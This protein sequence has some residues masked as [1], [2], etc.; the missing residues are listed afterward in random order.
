LR[1]REVA[2]AR[3]FVLATD[4]VANTQVVETVG[5]SATT[6]KARRER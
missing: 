3:A 5:V 2:R 6:V 1:H 4:G